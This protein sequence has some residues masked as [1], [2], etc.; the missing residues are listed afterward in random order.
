M[1]IIMKKNLIKISVLI[2][3]STIIFI[4]GCDKKLNV[5]PI[6]TLDQNILTNEKG[7]N[8]LLIGAYSLL[9]GYDG[10]YYGVEPMGT[11]LSNWVYG[12][13]AADDSYKGSTSGDIP[14]IATF[15]FW[16]TIPNNDLLNAKWVTMYKGVQ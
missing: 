10:S 16:R 3:F 15:Q 9:D 2:F 4:A 13:V 12:N 5:L 7:V 6:G 14:E 11:T 1:F 8:G